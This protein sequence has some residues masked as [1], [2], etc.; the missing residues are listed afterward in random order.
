M[1]ATHAMEAASYS[2][3]SLQRF[4]ETEDVSLL[5]KPLTFS[6]N[7]SFRNLQCCYGSI[8]GLASCGISA[9]LLPIGESL[10]CCLQPCASSLACTKLDYTAG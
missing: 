6:K 2:D 9:F 4:I 5:D 10:L 7:S 8:L 3:Q 1:P